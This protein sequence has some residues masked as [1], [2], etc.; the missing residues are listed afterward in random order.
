MAEPTS[1]ANKRR[2]DAAR[3]A[4][5]YFIAG[6]TQDE[7]AAQLGI[8]RQAAQRLVAFAVSENLIK[9][10]LDHPISNCMELAAA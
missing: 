10:R 5:L 2:E 6:R 7:I 4:W 1:G 3:A 8:S 9:F